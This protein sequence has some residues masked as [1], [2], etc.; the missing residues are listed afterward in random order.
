MEHQFRQCEP[1]KIIGVDSSPSPSCVVIQ[2]LEGGGYQFPVTCNMVDPDGSPL[3]VNDIV[4]VRNFDRTGLLVE[5][6]SDC[7]KYH[8]FRNTPFTVQ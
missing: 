2:L 1:I 6:L 4:V 7:S 3:R 8:L 5:R